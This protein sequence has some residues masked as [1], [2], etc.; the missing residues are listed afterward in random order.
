MELLR[1]Q[2]RPKWQLGRLKNSLPPPSNALSRFE[3]LWTSQLK[4]LISLEL[5][6]P[7]LVVIFYLVIF[8]CKALSQLYVKYLDCWLQNYVFSKSLSTSDKS[9]LNVMADSWKTTFAFV[10][11]H[12]SV[13]D[14][15]K[16]ELLFYFTLCQPSLVMSTVQLYIWAG[17]SP[18]IFLFGGSVNQISDTWYI[19]YQLVTFE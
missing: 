18:T 6:L 13:Y 7:Y 3:C 11:N 8:Y 2:L 1:G 16:E 12:P 4:M 14:S 19:R 15:W 9:I 5:S 17:S 10:Q